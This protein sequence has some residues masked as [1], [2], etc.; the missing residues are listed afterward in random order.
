[1]LENYAHL[2]TKFVSPDMVTLSNY[3]D[4]S[5][6][7]SN[8]LAASNYNDPNFDFLKQYKNAKFFNLRSTCDDDIH[9]AIKYGIWSSSHKK[10]KELND[11][12][13][14]TREP[15]FL[16]Y[17]VVGSNQ[18]CG[19]AKMES[20][21]DFSKSLPYWWDDLKWT[22]MFKISW[23]YIR[24]VH[25]QDCNGILEDGKPITS[26]RDGEPVS[27]E[28]GKEMFKLFKYHHLGTSVFDAFSFM[29]GREEKLRM[30]R[31]HKL[32]LLEKLKVDNPHLVKKHYN[33]NS[34]YQRK[35]NNYNNNYNRDSNNE[36][37]ND[38]DNNKKYYNNNKYS[39]NN[40]NY[41]KNYNNNRNYRGKGNYNQVE[42]V[43]KENN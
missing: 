24:D 40:N 38:H 29:D 36:N 16:I 18:F 19:I 8:Y 35:E 27:F 10:N 20:E 7:K 4:Q 12:F 21:V 43:P 34:N 17:S 37:N 28:N 1:M 11:A 30:D 6:I 14:T 26:L 23:V 25:Y 41:K 22:G 9:K 5:L 32:E 33:N 3:K 13:N 2:N 39:N 42:Y 15:I 31:D